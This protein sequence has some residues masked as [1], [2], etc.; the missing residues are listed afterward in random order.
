MAFS[1]V[2]NKPKPANFNTQSFLESARESAL[3][4]LIN[5]GSALLTKQNIN[6]FHC[7]T[8]SLFATKRQP[9]TLDGRHDGITSSVIICMM[10][11]FICAGS[12]DAGVELVFL[13]IES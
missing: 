5:A 6:R 4:T 11:G 3:F 12:S 10:V 1:V 13:G 7:F 9:H 2:K 8:D